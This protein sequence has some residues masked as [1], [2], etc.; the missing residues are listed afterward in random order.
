FANDNISKYIEDGELDL[1]IDAVQE[2]FESVLD[3]LLIDRENDPNSHETGRRLSKMYI[4]E[5]MSGRYFPKP[6]ATAFPNEGTD[7]YEGMIVI[8]AELKRICSHH[9]QPVSGT[10]FIGIIPNGKV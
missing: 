9:H 10:A 7:N 4:N 8:R 3:S 6:D 5:I 2:K 1:L